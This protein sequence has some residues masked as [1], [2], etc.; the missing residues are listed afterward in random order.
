MPTSPK[1]A[2]F[3]PDAP[4]QG[5]S[6]ETHPPDDQLPLADALNALYALHGRAPDPDGQED[7]LATLIATILSQSTTNINSARAFA[8][9]VDTFAGDWG[10][11]R[12]ASVEAVA[13]AIRSGGLAR[14]KAPRIQSILRKLHEADHP[15]LEHLRALPAQQALNALLSLNGVGPKTARFV[16]MWGAAAPLFAMDTHILRIARRMAWIPQ[17]ASDARAH[18]IMEPLI[19]DGQHWSAHVALIDHGRSICHPHHPRCDLCPLARAC[20]YIPPEADAP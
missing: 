11:V 7:L 2:F 9:L 14:Q 20:T 8:S 18:A 1:R 15:D 13:A 19:P 17:R 10:A 5:S 12:D 4:D 3:Q 6:Q 16:L